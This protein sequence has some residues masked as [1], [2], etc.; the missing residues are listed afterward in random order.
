[1][2]Q[3]TQVEVLSKKW[4]ERASK[5]LG[6]VEEQVEKQVEKQLNN[7]LKPRDEAGDTCEGVVQGVEGARQQGAG[8]GGGAG[9]DIPVTRVSDMLWRRS[10][11]R[12]S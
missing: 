8:G 5:E 11:W 9:G 10:R 1:M 12:S 3:A 6:E 7:D 2:K 4:K